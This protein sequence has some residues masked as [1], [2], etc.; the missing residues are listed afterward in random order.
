MFEREFML[1]F[2]KPHLWYQFQTL[3]KYEEFV[4]MANASPESRE[5]HNTQFYL[6]IAQTV[7]QTVF[8]ST[9]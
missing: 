4:Q 7:N 6:P 2:V 5:Y 3:C 9:W 1:H 8:P